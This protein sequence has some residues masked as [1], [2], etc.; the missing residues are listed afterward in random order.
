MVALLIYFH[1]CNRNGVLM[2]SAVLCFISFR[3]LLHS[4]TYTS[5]YSVTCKQMLN[6]VIYEI[7][8][9]LCAVVLKI[10]VT[11]SNWK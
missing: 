10:T 6:Q 9:I 1:Y 7:M 8:A 4:F 2:L 5:L 11:D 3:S